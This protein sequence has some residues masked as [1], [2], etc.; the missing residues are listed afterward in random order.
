[1][2]I[3]KLTIENGVAKFE[4]VCGEG[5]TYISSVK[6]TRVFRPKLR[7]EVLQVDHPDD[8]HK[9]LRNALADRQGELMSLYMQM[10]DQLKS[11]S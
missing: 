10:N 8:Y 7:R 3:T 2:K 1:V 6:L 5:Y 4:S 9:G 11:M